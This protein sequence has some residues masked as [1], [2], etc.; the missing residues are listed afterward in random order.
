MGESTIWRMIEVI[1]KEYGRTIRGKEVRRMPEA[2]IK[3]IYFRMAATRSKKP[4]HT[5]TSRCGTCSWW[6]GENRCEK[7]GMERHATSLAC[8]A[9]YDYILEENHQMTLFE[10]GSNV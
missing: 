8:R 1:E 3:A 7:L 10:G 9:H 5:M 6:T 4:E 2:Q